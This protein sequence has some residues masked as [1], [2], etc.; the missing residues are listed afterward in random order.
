MSPFNMLGRCTFQFA[1]AIYLLQLLQKPVNMTHVFTLYILLSSF[2]T[3]D[4]YCTKL[5]IFPQSTT[6]T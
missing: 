2:V 3:F 4:F 1:H 6:P 5:E